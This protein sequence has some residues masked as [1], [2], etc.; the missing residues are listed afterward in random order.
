[1]QQVD[2]GGSYHRGLAWTAILVLDLALDLAQ[3]TLWINKCTIAVWK[4]GAYLLPF[5][6]TA[7]D[8]LGAADR[9][10][11]GSR[12]SDR[13][14]LNFPAEG[15]RQ[16]TAFRSKR[17]A[18][19]QARGAEPRASAHRGVSWH[20]IKGQWRAEIRHEGR[21][22]YLG[23]F[24][25]ERV[26]AEAYDAAACEL[27]GDRARLNFPAEGERP[28]GSGRGAAGGRPADDG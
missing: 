1:M 12:H 18:T 19:E 8:P 23:Y 28:K 26:A 24:V 3:F 17:S 5:A 15:E 21:T 7:V 14:Q 20:K 11:S 13:V 9:T 16:G 25:D 27:H 10:N 22:K 4:G 6:G 2:N